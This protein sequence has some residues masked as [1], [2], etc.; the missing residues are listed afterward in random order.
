MVLNDGMIAEMKTG[1]GKTQMATLPVYLNALMGK[2]VHVV[3]VNDYLSRRDAVWMGQIY[4]LLGL[5]VAV[6]NS[7]ES[8]VY[9]PSHIT[10][11]AGET[12]E[13]AIA[14]A[15]KKGGRD[16]ILQGSV[17]ILA[18]RLKARRICCRCHV[19]NE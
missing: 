5:T 12:K 6:V 2:G 16:R 11:A 3:T 8:F 14:E 17:R 4:S 13:D 7:E 18:T 1:E 15:D 10:P 19:W 9:D